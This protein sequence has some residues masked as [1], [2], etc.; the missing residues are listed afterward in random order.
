MTVFRCRLFDVR[1]FDVGSWTA[2]KPL[3]SPQNHAP[4]HPEGACAALSAARIHARLKDLPVKARVI[5]WVGTEES[6]AL[7]VPVEHR[8]ARR[9]VA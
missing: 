8:V 1:L 9:L 6:W 7:L 2:R 5:M 3:N 4:C